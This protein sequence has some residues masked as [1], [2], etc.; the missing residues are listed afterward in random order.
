M[1]LSLT[2]KQEKRERH[3]LVC[4]SCLYIVTTSIEKKVVEE[5]GVC[6]CPIASRAF[7]GC[8]KGYF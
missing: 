2:L 7:I 8:P 4:R 1:A 6:G 3:K 5:C